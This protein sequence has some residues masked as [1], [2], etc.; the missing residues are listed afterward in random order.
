MN[1]LVDGIPTDVDVVVVGL[2]PVGA[3]LS[4]LLGRYGVNALAVDRAS[5]VLT[6]P[7][8]IALDQ[9][10]LRILQLA[11][12]KEGAFATVP[13]PFVRMRSP[14]LGVFGRMNTSGI[15]DGH[16]KLVTFYQPELEAAL[17]AQL[18][19]RESIFVSLATRLV[20]VSQEAEGV[21][22]ELVDA[23]GTSHAVRAK[24]LVGADGASSFVRQALGLGFEGH[25][26]GEDWL[27]VDARGVRKPIDHVEFICDP[28]RPIAHMVAPGGR[29]RWEFMLAPG[30]T[31]EMMEHPDKIRELL[32]PWGRPEEMFIERTAVYR[33]HARV[34]SR[35][36]AGRVFLVGDAAHVTPPF[37]GQ[38]LVSGLR[39]AANLAWKLGWVLSGRAGIHILESYDVERRPHARA[40][41]RL[42]REMG[43]LIMPTSRV[44]AGLTQ[45]V[46][47]SLRVLPPVRVLFDDMKAKPVSRF[48]QGLFAKG[49]PAGALC[50]GGLLPQT[51]VRSSDG[52]VRLS[53]D[54]LG[55]H[56]TLVGVGA[57]PSAFLD[58]DTRSAFLA[59]GGRCVQVS[60]PGTGSQNAVVHAATASLA[61]EALDEAL[62][63]KVAPEGWAAMV[64]PDRV[65]LH[66]GPVK[67][68]TR[69]VRE[70]LSML[71]A[72]SVVGSAPSA[73]GP[74]E[75]QSM[76]RLT[77]PEPARHPAPTARADCL[78][79]M[80]FE[81]PDLSLAT[82]FLADFGLH[83]TEA[84]TDALYFR[85]AGSAP[86]CVVVKSGPKPRF[87]GIGLRVCDRADLVALSR[88]A[89]GTGVAPLDAPGGGE[90]VRLVDPSGFIVDAVTGQSDA[91]PLSHREPLVLNNGVTQPRVNA[92]QRPPLE[93][94]AVLRLGHVVLEVAAFQATCAWYTR[95]FG[96][97]PSDV[98]VFRDGS[99]A[100]V[101]LR[102]DRGDTPTDHHTLAIAQGVAPAYG[103]SAY[104]LMDADAVAVGGRYLA[105][106]GWTHSWGIGRHVL[107]SQIFDYWCDPWG[108]KHEH[109]TDGDLVTSEVPMGVHPVSREAMAQ[110]GPPMPRSFTRPKF[111]PRFV[112]E[113]VR[114]VRRT[115]DLS[116]DKLRTLQRLFG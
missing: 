55:P 113:V 32:S 70:T 72:P 52:L 89:G 96:L 95:H 16:P 98:Q 26:Y 112:A 18:S 88:E 28:G 68:A 82:R 23:S 49:Q 76:L 69:L 36:S 15:E 83:L 27:I 20:A 40:M 1:A 71:G 58:A 114:S 42:A 14:Y 66:D 21:R 93:P 9:E 80:T 109:Y 24:F 79:F 47:K 7:R 90:V 115:P 41:V 33:F 86:F 35:F 43:R 64:R 39:D 8:A 74:K 44:R 25:T 46:V 97:I 103:H 75:R 87:T 110:W 99:P 19:E 6:H 22:A 73:D 12:L 78:S 31:R 48:R 105:E 108:D 106:H 107:G 13:I 50:R 111:S 17:R 116:L 56:L 92:T 2:G 54:A 30:E 5:S 62:F 53:D 65:V 84:R 85:A 38:G 102:L 37:A 94:S 59:A 60:A 3:A 29:E 91:A 34:V 51:R 4:C 57:D 11:G 81:R 63:P 77:T 10:A 100:V 101:F 104:E 45:G 67:E 61:W